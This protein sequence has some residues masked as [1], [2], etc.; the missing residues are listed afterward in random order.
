MLEVQINA[1][2]NTG[3]RV[4]LNQSPA[5]FGRDARHPLFIDLP[6]VSRVHGELRREPAGWVVANLSP[7]GTQVNGR[8]L[9]RKPRLLRDGDYIGVGGETLMTIHLSQTTDTPDASPLGDSSA[10]NPPVAPKTNRTGLWLGLL[11]FW[12]VVFTLAFVFV[13]TGKGTQATQGIPDLPALTDVD[14]AASIR[15]TLPR[16]EPSPRSALE[17]LDQAERFHRLQSADPSNAFRA[18]FAYKSAL[19]FSFGSSFTD[20]RDDWGNRPAAELALAQK[21]HIE[22]EEKLITEMTR[23]Y[24]DAYGKLQSGRY[25]AAQRAFKTIM[26]RYADPQNALFQNAERQ[27]DIARRRAKSRGK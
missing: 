25:A 5:G 26:D 8:S 22:L 17:Q 6:T 9:G 1:G 27:R 2:P 7:N 19:A 18:H 21:K 4:R 3:E 12:A 14:L 10:P 15:A 23:L 13:G 16:R 24:K 11:G 20:A